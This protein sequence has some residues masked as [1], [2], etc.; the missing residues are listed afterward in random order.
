LK[1]ASQERLSAYQTGTFKDQGQ[2][3]IA[4]FLVVA[5]FLDVT[6][7]FCYTIFK[8]NRNGPLI[9]MDKVVCSVIEL[10]SA[11]FE[12]VDGTSSHGL[13]AG[14]SSCLKFVI[15]TEQICLSAHQSAF[16]FGFCL[17][18]QAMTWISLVYQVW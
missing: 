15:Y 11:C 1:T 3:V 12:G 17:N 9:D 6:K 8:F 16:I 13:V 18:L 4:F 10:L 7:Y 5:S 14:E 2:I